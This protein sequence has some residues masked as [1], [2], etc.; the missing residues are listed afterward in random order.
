MMLSDKATDVVFALANYQQCSQSVETTT[1]ARTPAERC[2]NMYDPSVI[3]TP[4]NGA[5]TRVCVACFLYNLT[6]PSGGWSEPSI[7]ENMKS[8]A[9]K[10]GLELLALHKDRGLI[11]VERACRQYA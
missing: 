8:A 5:P 2:P 11:R 6:S 7:Q 1:W 4:L 10:A 3:Y 9:Y